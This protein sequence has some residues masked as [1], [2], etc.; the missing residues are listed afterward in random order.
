MYNK[1]IEKPAKALDSTLAALKE[2]TPEELAE[3]TGSDQPHVEIVFYQRK[4]VA[5]GRALVRAEIDAMQR[6]LNARRPAE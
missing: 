1:L 6:W 3:I 4:V 2:T 5:Q